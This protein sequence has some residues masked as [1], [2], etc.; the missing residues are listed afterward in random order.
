MENEHFKNISDSAKASFTQ[1]M[2]RIIKTEKYNKILK[3]VG[4]LP[5]DMDLGKA[6]R[7]L[8]SAEVVKPKPPITDDY[9]Q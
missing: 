6:I 1:E 8:V 7:T 4:E 2:D 5:N 9:I 3:L